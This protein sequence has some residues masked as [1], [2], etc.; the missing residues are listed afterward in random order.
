MDSAYASLLAQVIPVVLLAVLLELRVILR[1]ASLER[2]TASA[3]G[4]R[5]RLNVRYALGFLATY[6][7]VMLLLTRSEVV[8]LLAVAGRPVPEYEQWLAIVLIGV[9]L[10]LIVIC[11]AGLE[12]YSRFG[13][14]AWPRW[15]FTLFMAAGAVLLG[16]VAGSVARY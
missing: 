16:V 14:S 6:G 5:N 13:G 3:A 12:L 4:R 9:A 2:R 7:L 8:L 10:L 15:A 1:A 11:S